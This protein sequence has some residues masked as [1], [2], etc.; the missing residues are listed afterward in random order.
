MGSSIRR[1]E[2]HVAEKHPLYRPA[3]RHYSR[4]G[5]ASFRLRFPQI[6]GSLVDSNLF[7]TLYHLA[8]W[9]LVY[10]KEGVPSDPAKL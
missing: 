3:D 7:S 6:L 2:M 5:R 10:K 9:R 4:L 1:G 8:R